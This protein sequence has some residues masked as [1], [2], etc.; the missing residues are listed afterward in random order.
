MYRLSCSL[1]ML[2]VL[3]T[4]AMVPTFAE[5]DGIGW[6]QYRYDVYKHASRTW[7]KTE[8]PQGQIVWSRVIGPM[9]DVSP[10]VDPNTGTIYVGTLDSRRAVVAVGND[11]SQRWAIRLPGGPSYSFSF[12]YY[13]RGTPAIVGAELLVPGYRNIEVTDHSGATR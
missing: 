9:I 1:L 10:I 3:I 5:G 6:P 7:L 2:A 12:D 4:T 8:A 13:M 11:G